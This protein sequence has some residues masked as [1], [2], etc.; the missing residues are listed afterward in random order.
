MVLPGS[1][2]GRVGRRRI[3]PEIPGWV[4]PSGDFFVLAKNFPV[5]HRRVLAWGLAVALL[6]PHPR[7]AAPRLT[8]NCFAK[9]L[10]A[11]VVRALRPVPRS[12]K[13]EEG[14]LALRQNSVP[15]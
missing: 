2:G 13:S 7:C 9:V 12:L 15:D 11:K 6:L 3:Q 4:K 1:L 14:T 5:I 8:G 10:K